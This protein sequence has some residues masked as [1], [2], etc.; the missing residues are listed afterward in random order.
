MPTVRPLM[1]MLAVLAA[2]AGGCAKTEKPLVTTTDR[3]EATTMVGA[4]DQPL[5]PS[6]NTLWCATAPLAWERLRRLVDGP[7]SVA[8]GPAWVDAL[9]RSPV[10][11]A[12]VEERARVVDAGR[13][14]DGVIDRIADLV[15]AR[16]GRPDPLLAQ[17]RAIPP[18]GLV[19]YA[20]L[21]KDLRFPTSFDRHDT[22]MRFAWPGG[23]R[24]VP[25]LASTTSMGVMRA[26]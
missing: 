7:V 16:F 18:G 9:N 2:T 13:V 26:I 22:P 23:T 19:A 4:L 6:V 14:G 17:M 3:L 25:A 12:D 24:R 15:Q 5:D 1:L 11:E 8:D 21:E 10:T 20:R